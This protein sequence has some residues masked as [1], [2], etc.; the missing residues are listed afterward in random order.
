MTAGEHF[1]QIL[2]EI[3]DATPGKMFGAEAI[4][5]PNGKAGAFFKNDKI[6]VKISGETLQEALKLSGVGLFTPKENRPMNNWYEIPFEHKN[7]WKK[8]AEI[9]CAEVAKLEA[10][11]KKSKK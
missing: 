9:S 1:N 5:M 7:F 2:S 11:P 3:P 4:K 10:K 6:I 8:H